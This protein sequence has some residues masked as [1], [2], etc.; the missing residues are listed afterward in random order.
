MPAASVA[1]TNHSDRQEMEATAGTGWLMNVNMQKVYLFTLFL[2]I[3]S[4]DFSIIR[5]IATNPIQS[6]YHQCF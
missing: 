3:A 4:E 2:V 5:P 1:S 6:L